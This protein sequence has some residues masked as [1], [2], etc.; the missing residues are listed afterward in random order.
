MALNLNQELLT[1]IVLEPASLKK[2][3]ALN[4]S[5]ELIGDPTTRS[6]V[7]FAI[8]H[9]EKHGEAPSPTVMVE[10]FGNALSTLFP[11]GEIPEPETE[12]GYIVDKLKDRY[13]RGAH[14]D[15]V[16][17]LAGLRADPDGFINSLVQEGNRLWKISNDGHGTISNADY[18]EVIERHQL[19]MLEGRFNGITY[20]FSDID[21]H[22]GGARKGHVT[23]LGALPKRFKTWIQL[24]GFIEQRKAGETPVL[25]T[26]EL[27]PDEIW[28]RIFCM[29]SGVS[30]TD[31]ITGSLMKREWNKIDKAAEEFKAL[32][33]AYVRQS[34]LDKRK[35]GDILQD[36]QRFDATS[37]LIDQLSYLEPSKPHFKD[38]EGYREICHDIKL[39]ATKSDIPFWVNCQLNREAANLKEMASAQNAGLT[40]AI[41]ETCDLFLGLYRNE[42]MIE[43]SQVQI[44]VIEGR[45]C[46]SMAQWMVNVELQE[47]T[48][49][50]I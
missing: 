17:E 16:R 31:Y 12:I 8:H 18:K 45:H 30:Y 48:K 5:D 20:G 32:G 29:L 25:F 1:H 21:T 42:D 6:I 34:P 2:L 38:H 27:S 22:T 46:P 9:L 11:E 39:L 19:A 37:V 40:R 10:E 41:E 4:F 26:L 28:Y 7:Q 3:R 44:G 15:I 43:R 49:F 50:Y 13:V 33:P 36:A 47:S 23:Y 14:A 35:V 24:Q